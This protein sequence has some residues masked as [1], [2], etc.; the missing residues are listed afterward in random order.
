M[1][2]MKGVA[3][4]FLLV[5]EEMGLRGEITRRRGGGFGVLRGTD[6]EQEAGVAK[7]GFEWLLETWVA[8]AQPSIEYTT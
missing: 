7:F 6:V 5:V 4:S 2:D 1:A 8:A 3:R